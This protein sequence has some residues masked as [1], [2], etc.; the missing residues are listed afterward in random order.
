MGYPAGRRRKPKCDAGVWLVLDRLDCHL[1]AGH[2][3]LHEHATEEGQ[4]VRWR[5]P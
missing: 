2:P 1:P 3:G 5:L 4:I